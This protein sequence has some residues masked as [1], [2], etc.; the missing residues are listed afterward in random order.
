MSQLLHMEN[1]ED[2]QVF[3]FLSCCRTFV[4]V[5]GTSR[6]KAKIIYVCVTNAS[7]CMLSGERKKFLSQCC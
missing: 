6:I 4:E 5:F 3:A 1:E 7:Q 2:F